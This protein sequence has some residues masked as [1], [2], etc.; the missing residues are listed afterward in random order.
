[1]KL[2][3]REQNAARLLWLR[4]PWGVGA[5]GMDL[6]GQEVHTICILCVGKLEVI[7]DLVQTP[8]I[9]ARLCA[10]TYE[11]YESNDSFQ[12]ESW[13]VTPEVDLVGIEWQPPYITVVIIDSRMICWPRF[14]RDLDP[15]TNLELLIGQLV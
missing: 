6:S 13:P 3:F 10:R 8:A 12:A 7:E 11:L 14:C 2:E 4:I 1:M 15:L 5:G 9:S